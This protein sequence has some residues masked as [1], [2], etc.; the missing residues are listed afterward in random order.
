[1]KWLS[2]SLD[3]FNRQLGYIKTIAVIV[4]IVMFSIA[5]INNGCQRDYANDLIERV[6][7][8][9]VQN[10]ILKKRN[11]EIAEN[12]DSLKTAY[13][14]LEARYDKTDSIRNVYSG[15]I[16][17]LRY[18]RDTL[19]DFIRRTPTGELYAWL[20]QIRFPYQGEKVYKFNQPQVN[21]IYYVTKDYDIVREENETLSDDISECN[22][23]LVLKDSLLNNRVQSMALM[24]STVANSGEIILNL[25]EKV[26]ITEDQVKKYKRKLFWWKV[27]TGVAVVAGVILAL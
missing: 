14:E 1:M 22:Y 3:W 13:G 21:D 5:A 23:Q 16:A 12:L 8:L 27:G 18:Q 26:E 10:D 15:I 24:K 4:L 9:D 17:D 2:D 20:D 25:E 11:K 6:T 19:K 7:G